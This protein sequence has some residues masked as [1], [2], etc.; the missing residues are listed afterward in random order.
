MN[1]REIGIMASL[2]YGRSHDHSTAKLWLRLAPNTQLIVKRF[3]QHKVTFRHVPSYFAMLEKRQDPFD[4]S[5][6]LC[7]LASFCA[8]KS[9][10]LSSRPCQLSGD[11]GFR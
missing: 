2:L 6:T 10:A 7:G 11:F 9:G 8:L 1:K 4:A 5:G 3:T